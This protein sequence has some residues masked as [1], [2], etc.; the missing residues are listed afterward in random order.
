MG[1]ANSRRNYPFRAANGHSDPNSPQMIQHAVRLERDDYND[2]VA[3]AKHRNVTVGFCLRELIMM[4][5]NIEHDMQENV[6]QE[7]SPNHE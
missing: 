2:V 5:L 7:W 6:P 3:L 1:S 4:A